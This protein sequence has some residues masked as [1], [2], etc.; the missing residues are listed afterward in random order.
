MASYQNYVSATLSHPS[1]KALANGNSQATDWATLNLTD[2]TPSGDGIFVA[3]YEGGYAPASIKFWPYCDGPAGSVF[4]VRVYGWYE[5]SSSPAQ[6]GPQCWYYE[7]L[8]EFICTSCNVA[9]IHAPQPGQT[10][11]LTTLENLCD[12]I[13][14]VQGQ[15]SLIN[16]TRQGTDLVA[17]AKVDLQRCRLFRFDFKPTDQVSMNCL[18]MR[19]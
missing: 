12:T 4:S 17:S 8:G 5:L 19:L 11:Y 14:L 15:A 18:W 9:G 7:M 6:Q 13:A 3:G 1:Q 2:V 16:S 10:G